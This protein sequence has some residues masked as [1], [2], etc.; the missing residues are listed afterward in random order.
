[1]RRWMPGWQ[2]WGPGEMRDGLPGNDGGLS[3]E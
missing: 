2:K 3:G 1:M